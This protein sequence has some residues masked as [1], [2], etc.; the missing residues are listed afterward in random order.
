MTDTLSWEATLGLYE[1]IYAFDMA[2]IPLNYIYKYMPQG[3]K[4]IDIDGKKYITR[5]EVWRGEPW[6][7]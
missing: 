3:Y 7:I 5:M 1:N 6:L 2:I 4:T